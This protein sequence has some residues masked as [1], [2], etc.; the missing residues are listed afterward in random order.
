MNS[1][2]LVVIA[3]LFSLSFIC[4]CCS[5]LNS[6]NNSRITHPNIHYGELPVQDY[7]FEIIDEEYR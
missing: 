5:L 1:K 4:S 3:I 7:E 6:S 2:W